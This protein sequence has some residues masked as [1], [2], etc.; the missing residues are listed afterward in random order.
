MTTPRPCFSLSTDSTRAVSIICPKAFFASRA[1]MVLMTET[2][3]DQ[4]RYLERNGPFQQALAIARGALHPSGSG[5][6]TAVIC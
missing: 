5:V 3:N 1:D 6:D 2:R 4:S